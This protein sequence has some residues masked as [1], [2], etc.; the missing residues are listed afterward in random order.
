MVFLY[1]YLLADTVRPRPRG[2]PGAYRS[3]ATAPARAIAG[4]A[5]MGVRPARTTDRW[6][7]RRAS[8]GRGTMAG[9]GRG[10]SDAAHIYRLHRRPKYTPLL[11]GARLSRPGAVLCIK[12]GVSDDSRRHTAP[13]ASPAWWTS[14][15]SH[16]VVQSYAEGSLPHRLYFCVALGQLWLKGALDNFLQ[17]SGDRAT[18]ESAEY[19]D[20][21]RH[22]HSLRVDLHLDPESGSLQQDLAAVSGPLHF[23]DQCAEPAL[24]LVD[25]GL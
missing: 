18:K 12:Q 7:S 20:I 23:L 15:A 17:T 9:G 22:V 19:G 25:G 5:D 14:P 13:C 11:S 21:C 24:E 4:S 3:H 6:L 16:R 2:E 8:H 1:T 10:G